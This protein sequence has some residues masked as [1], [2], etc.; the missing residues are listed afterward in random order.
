LL[1]LLAFL[2]LGEQ[3]ARAGHLLSNDK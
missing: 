2:L 3:L 1:H